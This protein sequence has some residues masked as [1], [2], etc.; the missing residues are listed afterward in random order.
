[1]KTRSPISEKQYYKLIYTIQSLNML[2]M[3]KAILITGVSGGIG[4]ACAK[5]F[6]DEGYVVFG[7]DIKA[8]KEEKEHLK[9]VKTD[10]T[11]ENE[12]ISAFKQIKATSYKLDAILHC[13]GICDLNSLIEMSEEDFIR[14]FDIN[15]FASFRVN[16]AFLPILK[17]KGKIILISSEQ[18]PQDPLPFNG[19]YGMSKGLVEKYA[20]SLRMELQLLGYQ[21]VVIRP[22][23]V[24]TQMLKGS[25]NK[26]EEFTKN[27]TH[28]QYNSKRFKEIVES[29]ESK[30]LPPSKIANLIYKVSNKKKPRYVYKINTNPGLIF[31]NILPKR[32]QNW[33]I[34]KILTSK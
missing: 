15:V 13:A 25:Q 33:V 22:G 1:M 5:K 19:I 14:T 21:V 8:P 34:K 18:G 4:S 12:V 31:L 3:E 24:N 26:L 9:F 6:L 23:A 32:F 2:N 29:V 16:K 20:Y 17:E 11:K 10:L 28:Y 7:L 27:T 30:N